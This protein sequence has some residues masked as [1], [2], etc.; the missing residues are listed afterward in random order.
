VTGLDQRGN[1][2]YFAISAFVE[3]GNR[4]QENVRATKVIALDVDCGDNKP[5]PTWKEGLAATGSSSSRWGYP[6]R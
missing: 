6:N 1:N 2:T 4:K 5:Y 3:K